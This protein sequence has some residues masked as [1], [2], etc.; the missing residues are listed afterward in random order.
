M[1][2]PDD[3]INKIIQG[4]CVE[5][6]KTFPD[7]YV[8]TLVCDPPYG[9]AFMGKE[10]DDFGTD[11]KKFQEW[12]RIWAVEAFRV[13]KPGATLLCFGGTRTF[14][15][16]TC[17]LED[18]G[19]QI[20]DVLMWLYGS[21]FP[22]SLDISKAIDKMKGVER[23]KIEYEHW[24]RR[25]RSYQP[26]G[27]PFNFDKDK[28]KN[29][30]YKT[31]PTTSEAK[32]WEG[33]G[34]SLKPAYEPIIMAMKPKDG[35]YAN[36]ALKWGVAG[37]NIDGCR[38]GTHGGVQKVNI[39]P[40]SG[41]FSGEGFGCNG[42]LIDLNKGRFPANVILDEESAKML[43]EQSGITTSRPDYRTNEIKKSTVPF[44]NKRRPNLLNDKGG[45]SR[46][47]YCAKA[48]KSERTANR[49]I[50]NDHPTLKPLELIKYLVKLATPP[51]GLILDPFVG[52]GTTCVACKILGYDC[53]GIERELN[54]VEIANKRLEGIRV[55][56]VLF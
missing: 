48:S 32:E 22:K 31:L 27:S 36:N 21:G 41:G 39:V 46:F 53:I 44:C 18:A 11:L 51:N 56:D 8:T 34:T 6:M 38:I 17:G 30:Q 10:W 5:V 26:N 29:K 43:D 28:V 40:N 1:K 4:D 35:S 3:F 15:R 50:E 2:Y 47:F 9:L 7:N 55:N 12:V 52:S 14:H 54:Y 49:Q 33:Y 42:E 16:L 19:W 13:A 23:E 24:G 20:K 45:A 37:L 25:N